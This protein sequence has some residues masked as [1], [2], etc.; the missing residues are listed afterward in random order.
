M[1]PLL[2]RAVRRSAT[3]LTLC[4]MKFAPAVAP[5]AQAP[6]RAAA[7][8]APAASSVAAA[9][10][11]ARTAQVTGARAP[12]GPVPRLR[13]VEPGCARRTAASTRTP[14]SIIG[15]LRFA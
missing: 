2:P 4:L 6:A 15:S 3:A 13:R 10:A 8:S 1:A 9:Q 11:D 5:A 14:L 7:G 12:A